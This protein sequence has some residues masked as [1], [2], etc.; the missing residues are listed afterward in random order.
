MTTTLRAGATTAPAAGPVV[1][2]PGVY[3]DM[4]ADVYHADPALSSTGARRLLPPGCPA[5]FRHERDNP[6]PPRP[7]FEFG[8][9]A[10]RLVLGDGPELV[11]L[12]YP[13]WRT[14]AAREERAEVR[15]AGAVPLLRDD[16]D[17]VAAMADALRA[18]PW[19]GQLFQPDTGRPEVSLFWQD[20]PTGVMCRA[21]LDWL[22]NPGPGRL[23]LRDYKTT[24]AA[25]LAACE[26]T[27]HAYGYHQQAA[28]YLAG[29]Q[30]LGLAGPDAEFLLVFQ[31]RTAPYLVT[32][33]QVAADALRVGAAKNRCALEVYAE[34]TATGRWP[35][36]HNDTIAHLS[37]P[38]WAMRDAEEYL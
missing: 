5:L 17:R 28:W 12:D 35:G 31:E 7:A 33:A 37:L 30:A 13:D 11:P 6:P 3:P 36:H 29:A 18:H 26:R 14:K 25:D 34:C 21:R 19:S 38:P 9:A 4:P 8:H 15:A 10:H 32:V 22:P 2:E 27:I 16:Y 1:T 24:P 23:I 20:G